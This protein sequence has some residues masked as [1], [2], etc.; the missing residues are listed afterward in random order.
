MYRSI[1][2]SIQQTLQQK[3]PPIVLIVGLRQTGKSTLAKSLINTSPLQL[4]NFDLMSDQAE[5]LNQNRHTL[6][7]FARRYAQYTIIIDEVQ[8][9]PEATNI[10]KHLYD[11]YHL[12]FLLTGSSELKI[13]RRIGDSLA[14]RIKQYRLYPLSI[15]EL[16]IQRGV[17]SEPASQITFDLCQ[18]ILSSYLVYGSLPKLENISIDEYTTHLFSL[19][20]GLLTTDILE[21][22]HIKKS[23]KIV[24]LARLLAQQ[25]GQLVNIAE[26]SILTEL[27]RVSIY[28]Y[29][30]IFEQ[31]NIIC[32][33]Y[34]L[35][36][37]NRRAISA[38]FKI[39]FTD[40]GIRN[41]LVNAFNPI[42]SRL[43]TGPLL[44][45]AVY[46]GIKRTMEYTT[47][48]AY[49]LG[50]FRDRNGS[51][52]DIVLRHNGKEHL[53]EVKSSPKYMNKKGAVTYITMQNA[54]EY[55]Q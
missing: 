45:N 30:D 40:L 55:L 18:P 2:T 12:R 53:Y 23:T 49:E 52:L 37:N 19:S 39:Y 21:L 25:I 11:Q 16:L 27:S 50:F 32:R 28:R 51:E 47:P 43:D 36:T 14:G 6:A 10:I 46:M 29:L 34:P 54:W 42:Q 5:F 3:H 1:A 15:K 7:E 48:H 8:K 9:C 38:K 35:S 33:A 31:L 13:T 44:E 24:A 41:A 4:F 26:L 22:E 17:L 20:E